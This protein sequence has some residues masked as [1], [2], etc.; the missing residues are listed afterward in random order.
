MF[1]ES[2]IQRRL[3]SVYDDTTFLLHSASD[4][5]VT[6]E[7]IKR[8]IAQANPPPNAR[9][10]HEK[11][12]KL[13]YDAQS[14]Q[15][16]M[17]NNVAV[18]ELLWETYD[19]LTEA[20]CVT[21][22]SRSDYEDKEKE[23]RRPNNRVTSRIVMLKESER[24]K[25]LAEE[26]FKTKMEAFEEE[27]KQNEISEKLNRFELLLQ[28]TESSLKSATTRIK[29]TESMVYD[30]LVK[31]E[32]NIAK[33]IAQLVQTM[34]DKVDDLHNLMEKNT[35]KILEKIDQRFDILLQAQLNPCRRI[36]DSPPH[37]EEKD[38]NERP[39]KRGQ[40]ESGQTYSK[41]RRSPVPRRVEIARSKLNSLAI[42]V[43][44]QFGPSSHRPASQCPFCDADSTHIPDACP[45]VPTIEQ[46][47]MEVRRRKLCKK[48]LAPQ[49]PGFSSCSTS[50]EYCHMTNHNTALCY[51]P[52][53]RT[54]LQTIIDD[55][56][57][58]HDK[59]YD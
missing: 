45:I 4:I 34:N 50:C 48:C 54:N 7:E 15:L 9:E 10:V 25:E 58:H 51:L 14:V 24:L 37:R 49:H 32:T 36:A 35:Q 33:P 28:E 57:Y 3:D 20:G 27:P 11:L 23:A 56:R 5:T 44:R 26:I 47:L 53:E 1:E 21:K 38:E 18:G 6:F 19:M 41:K 40:E 42:C 17:S 46:R 2:E 8:A 13:F 12:T 59:R 29:K 30:K 39:R 43:E 22:Q 16:K 55:W 52:E 31:P